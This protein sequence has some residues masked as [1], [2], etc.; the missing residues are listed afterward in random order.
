MCLTLHE[1]IVHRSESV[2]DVG[3]KSGNVRRFTNL[4]QVY[5]VCGWTW[6]GTTKTWNEDTRHTVKGKNQTFTMGWFVVG[7]STRLG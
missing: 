1:S 7:T 2:S 6:I 4:S 5:S 3:S